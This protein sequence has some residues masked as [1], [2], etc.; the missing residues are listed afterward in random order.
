M[1]IHIHICVCIYIFLCFFCT[2]PLWIG[3]QLFSAWLNNC[4]SKSIKVQS[5]IG[6]LFTHQFPPTF[7]FFKNS[8]LVAF[9]SDCLGLWNLSFNFHYYHFFTILSILSFLA[10]HSFLLN[11]I[12]FHFDSCFTDDIWLLSNLNIY[13]FSSENLHIIFTLSRMLKWI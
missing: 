6:L 10:A 8:N 1:C 11:I 9:V 12:F 7:F 4:W 2:L 13:K 3:I 5:V